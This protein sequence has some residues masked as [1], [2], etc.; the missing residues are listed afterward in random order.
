MIV[1]N[2][3]TARFVTQQGLQ[4]FLT[5][6][7]VVGSAAS[8]G[9]AWVQCARGLVDLLIVDPGPPNG[10]SAAL[11]QTL[12]GALPQLPV[13]VLTAYD[14]PRLRAQMQALGVRHYLAKPIALPELA[15]IVRGV[16][17]DI[18]AHPGVEGR[19]HRLVHN[20]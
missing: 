5:H 19:V 4:H 14:T 2:D 8:P 6:Q 13:L 12:R 20:G 15:Q 18:Q 7:A 17:A 10:A 1:D 3:P 11:V 9:T 16:L